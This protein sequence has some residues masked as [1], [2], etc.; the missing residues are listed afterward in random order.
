MSA[1]SLHNEVNMNDEIEQEYLQI[2]GQYKKEE[3]SYFCKL[4][5]ILVDL[6][7]PEPRD[8]IGGLYMELELG[9]NNTGQFFTPPEISLMMA[10]MSY[11]GQL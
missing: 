8:V 1:I 7:E 5:A 9:N 2:V 4:L 6:M 3:I 10:K 11:G